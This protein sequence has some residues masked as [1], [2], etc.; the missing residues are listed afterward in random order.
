MK[1]SSS[2]QNV[3]ILLKGLIIF[4]QMFNTS[5]LFIQSV[6]IND[7]QTKARIDIPLRNGKR[8]NTITPKTDLLGIKDLS[9]VRAEETIKFREFLSPAI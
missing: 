3:A 4:M 2:V 6:R 1:K 5:P 9:V 8:E 7:R